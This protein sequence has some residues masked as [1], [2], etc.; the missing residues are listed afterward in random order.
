MPA[1]E[2]VFSNYGTR[3]SFEDYVKYSI[4]DTSHRLGHC[5]VLAPRVPPPPPAATAAAATTAADPTVVTAHA[6]LLAGQA[7]SSTAVPGT[8]YCM[9]VPW[10]AVG[11]Q[12]QLDACLIVYRM[13]ELERAGGLNVT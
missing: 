1:G 10:D 11:G 7:F 3:C 12:V 5:A 4:A 6:A 8:R 2:E 9:V 13:V